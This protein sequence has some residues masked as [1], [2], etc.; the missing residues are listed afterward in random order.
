[1]RREQLDRALNPRSIAVVGD[2]GS[3]NYRW[4]RGM[5]T[6]GGQ[7]YSVQLDPREIPG[8]EALGVP[9][10]LSLTDIPGEVDYVLVAVPRQVAPIVL[11]D[12]IAKGVSGVGMFTS[13]FSE[14]DS[15]EGRTLEAQVT[16][17]ARDADLA[18][19]GPNCL[20]LYDPALGVRFGPNLATGFSGDVTFLSQS[21]GH[22][23]DFATTAY[24]QGVPVHKALSFGNGTVL[25]VADFLEYFSADDSTR[26][27]S[28]Y[29]EGM[30]QGR[31]FLRVLRETTLRKPV[32]IWKGGMSDA[33]RRA[34]SSHTASLAGS[35]QVWDALYRQSGAIPVNSVAEMVDVLKA[36]RLLTPFTGTGIG[37]T[38]GSGGQSVAMAD[39]FSGAGL[40]VPALSAESTERLA[41]W[42]RVIGASYGNPIDSGANVAEIETIMDVL[43]SDPGISCLVVQMRPAA[44]DPDDQRR[45]DALLDAITGA[46]KR[47][48][49]PV[50]AV[51]YSSTPL[52]EGPALKAV[53][54]R[55]R[56]IEV[57]AFHTYE[58]AAQAIAKVG[59]YYR[60]REAAREA[61]AGG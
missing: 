27:I 6:F 57:P 31:R 48:G 18:L 37:I 34:T 49:K 14:S 1:M 39:V 55:L 30:R 33:G 25:G 23:N 43:A 29:L 9:N 10:Y 5:S 7:L 11:R 19:I 50:A 21:G 22:G 44:T 36:L 59:A 45:F 58:Q 46:R 40:T 35:G 54:D 53:H 12:C 3:R 17:M 2:A 61:E 8:I 4:L 51:V 47:S 41:S 52:D 28:I 38:G 16:E 13:G 24:A 32:V 20:G 56:E 26:F 60:F 42:F 15:E